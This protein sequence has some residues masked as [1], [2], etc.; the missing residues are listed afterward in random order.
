[1]ET[2]EPSNHQ[3]IHHGETSTRKESIPPLSCYTRGSKE[4]EKPLPFFFCFGFKN[5]NKKR[6]GIIFFF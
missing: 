6:G 2:R 4:Q 1:L 5:K 3:R